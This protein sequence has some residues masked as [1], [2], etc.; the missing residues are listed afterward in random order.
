MHSIA[1]YNKFYGLCEDLI[2]TAEVTNEIVFINSIVF[3]F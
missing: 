2:D 1:Y 3:A